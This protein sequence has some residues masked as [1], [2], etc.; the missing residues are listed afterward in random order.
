MGC[1]AYGSAESQGDMLRER[2]RGTVILQQ[3]RGAL[4]LR[5]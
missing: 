1:L 5:P 2:L 3:G 4:T